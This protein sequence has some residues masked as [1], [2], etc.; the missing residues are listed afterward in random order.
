MPCKGYPQNN[1]GVATT[2]QITYWFFCYKQ[3]A[4]MGLTEMTL[5]EE[6]PNSDFE[7]VLPKY[8]CLKIFIA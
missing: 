4:P 3:E 5:P 7:I 1:K 6:P 2:W 8:L